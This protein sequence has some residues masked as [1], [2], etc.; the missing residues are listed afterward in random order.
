MASIAY[1]DTNRPVGG[2]RPMTWDVLIAIALASNVTLNLFGTMNIVIRLFLHPVFGQSF[3]HTKSYRRILGILLESAA[4]N[5]PV[6]I[7]AIPC[8]F[9]G[10]VLMP[11]AMT[12]VV[13][14]QVR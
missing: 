14:G 4:L 5:I 12:F 3:T 8:I 2:D 7:L 11:I 13:H 1:A 6:T 10:E 9:V